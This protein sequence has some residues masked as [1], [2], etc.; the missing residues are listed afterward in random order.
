[1]FVETIRYLFSISKMYLL[2]IGIHYAASHAYV[3]FCTEGTIWGFITSPF[4]APAPHCSALRWLIYTGGNS[5]NTMWMMLGLWL[6]GHL[7]LPKAVNA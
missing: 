6:I 4:L 1:M 5:I 7:A 2:W 3:H